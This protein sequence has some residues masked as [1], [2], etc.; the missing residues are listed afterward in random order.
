MATY[1]VWMLMP[2]PDDRRPW[3]RIAG[4]LTVDEADVY[5][6]TLLFEHRIMSDER[7]PEGARAHRLAA[8]ESPTPLSRP[9]GRYVGSAD[10]LS[11]R[12]SF[13]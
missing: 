3:S 12:S 6:R 1:S 13:G 5:A 4:G 2:L 10:P 9:A 8:D 11:T 7:S